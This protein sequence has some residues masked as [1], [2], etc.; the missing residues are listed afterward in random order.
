VRATGA[1]NFRA[2]TLLA[3]AALVLVLSIT[4]GNIARAQPPARTPTTKILAIGTLGP[5]ADPHE[6]LLILPEEVRA[7]AQLYLEGRIDQW[8]SLEDHGGV[9][10]ILNLQDIPA[11]HALLEQLPLGRAHLMT[12]ELH[13][14]GPLN[15]LRQLLHSNTSEAH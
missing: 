13:P 5:H 6:A 15:P 3:A 14:I 9:V 1:C 2:L 7:T 10:F 4:S 11:A 12:F 8:Y